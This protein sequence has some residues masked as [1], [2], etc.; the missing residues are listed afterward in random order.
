MKSRPLMV[1]IGPYGPFTVRQL[2]AKCGSSISKVLNPSL[3]FRRLFDIVLNVVTKVK[4]WPLYI[5]AYE[6]FR[7]YVSHS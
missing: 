6:M 1:T 4:F 2:I 3:I 7:S 5:L